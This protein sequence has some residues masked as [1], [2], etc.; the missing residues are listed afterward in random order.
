MGHVSTSNVNTRVGIVLYVSVGGGIEPIDSGLRDSKNFT[1]E[2]NTVRLIDCFSDR[3]N[4]NRRRNYRTNE[5]M[6]DHPL[7][8]TD[9]QYT[10]Y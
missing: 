5:Q 8:D 9:L 10:V 6:S 7:I 4:D 3:T 1:L 2:H